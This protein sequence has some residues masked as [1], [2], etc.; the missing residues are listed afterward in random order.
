[1]DDSW[2]SQNLLALTQVITAIVTAL[3]TVALWRVT[4]VL[5]DET[6]RLADTSSHAQ[7]VATIEPNPWSVIHMDLRVANTGN[8]VAFDVLVSF[9]P[10]LPKADGSPRATIPLQKISLLRPGQALTSYLTEFGKI[11]GS[12]FKVTIS[13]KRSPTTATR[14]TVIY[15]LN[16]ADFDGSSWLGARDP[17]TEIAEQVKKIREDWRYVSTGYN[18]LKVNI[19]TEQDNKN[20]HERVQEEIEK[21]KAQS[22]AVP[23]QIADGQMTTDERN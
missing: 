23:E 19:F 21:L 16:M 20:E 14:E 8:A 3:A 10:P 15:E 7:V 1:M 13:W 17:L 9:D 12:T 4:R 5:A 22:K 2:S 11:K 18:R 6:R